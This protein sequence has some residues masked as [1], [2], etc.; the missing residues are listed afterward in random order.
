MFTDL[1]AL[2]KATEY[3][4]PRQPGFVPDF[5]KHRS[6]MKQQEHGSYSGSIQ[7]TGSVV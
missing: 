5:E 4:G 7:D 3:Q 1:R 2:R 6:E